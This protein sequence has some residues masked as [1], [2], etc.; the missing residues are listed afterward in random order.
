MQV[1]MPFALFGEK[2]KAVSKEGRNIF[3]GGDVLTCAFI[4][5]F[6]TSY[7]VNLFEETI[8][9]PYPLLLVVFDLIIVKGGIAEIN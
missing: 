5:E 9:H 2:L 3:I 8:Y 6:C 7:F 4:N 1:N